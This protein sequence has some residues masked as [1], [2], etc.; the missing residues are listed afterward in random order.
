MNSCGTLPVYVT[1]I[2][3][4]GSYSINTQMHKKTV[5]CMFCGKTFEV[6]VDEK[7]VICPHCGKEAHETL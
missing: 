6:R 1:V 5:F 2:Y 3:P 4:D 7:V